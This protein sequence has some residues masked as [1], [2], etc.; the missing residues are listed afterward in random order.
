MLRLSFKF[1][2]GSWFRFRSEFW[3]ALVVKILMRNDSM[4]SSSFGKVLFKPTNSI[5]NEMRSVSLKLLQILV[6]QRFILF[7]VF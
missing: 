4:K 1:V 7:G 3:Q 5:S 6:T 2:F